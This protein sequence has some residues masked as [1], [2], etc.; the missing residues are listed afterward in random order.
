MAIRFCESLGTTSTNLKSKGFRRI[1]S[2]VSYTHL[3]DDRL[4]LCLD[5][6]YADDVYLDCQL[7]A[8]EEVVLNVDGKYALQDVYKRQGQ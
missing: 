1:I 6:V 8:G 3:D 7:S 2:S 4:E 5:S